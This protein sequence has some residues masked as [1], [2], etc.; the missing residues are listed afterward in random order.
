M[1]KTATNTLIFRTWKTKTIAAVLAVLGAV[2]V[3]A[4]FL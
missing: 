3:I 2:G 1:E 4:V